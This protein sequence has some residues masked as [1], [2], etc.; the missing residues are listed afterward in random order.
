MEPSEK[1]KL[2]TDLI[3]AI[4]ERIHYA[5]ERRS[6]FIIIS[7]ALIAS[8]VASIAFS[9]NELCTWYN[10]LIFL[11]SLCFIFLSLFILFLYSKQTNYYTFSSTNKKWFYRK[12][13]TKESDFFI[14]FTD[15]IFRKKST[16]KKTEKLFSE[17]K[18]EFS[19]NLNDI[20][21]NENKDINENND[22][23]FT[24]HL[25]E[26]YKN[27]YLT[28]LRKTLTR[29]IYLTIFVVIIGMTFFYFFQS[30]NKNNCISFKNRVGTSYYEIRLQPTGGIR[31]YIG[32]NSEE[33]YLLNIIATE[34]KTPIKIRDLAISNSFSMEIPF[35][36]DEKTSFPFDLPQ[37]QTKVLTL[38][39]P[40]IFCHDI[41]NI[42]V[43]SE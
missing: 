31:S 42:K 3:T 10:F 39:I 29:G 16:I 17:A 34:N 24:L 5:E 27:L 6:K 22:Q 12:A 1:K 25:V 33:E 4:S 36:I 40:K 41:E 20:F 2:Q 26:K 35:I 15:V 32:G 14:T 19:K 28:Q 30:P 37:R 13:L 8:G 38:W 11:A 43:L 9:I 7:T 23:I 18:N 21:D